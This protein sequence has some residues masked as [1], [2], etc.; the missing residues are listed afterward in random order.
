MRMARLIAPSSRLGHAAPVLEGFADEPLSRDRLVPVLYPDRVQVD[1]ALR[2]KSNTE[3]RTHI[4]GHAD[5]VQI[6][7]NLLNKYPSNWELSVERS[8]ITAQYLLD[9]TDLNMSQFI[10]NGS[11]L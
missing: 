5:A 4:M 1:V 6:G 3:A 10:I 8:M 7:D 9:K 11:L 2:I